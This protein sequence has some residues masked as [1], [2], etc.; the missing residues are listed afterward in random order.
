M[1]RRA[2]QAVRRPLLLFALVTGVAVAPAHAEPVVAISDDVASNYSDSRL[3]GLG[4]KHARLIT[5]WDS[6]SS[7]SGFVQGWLDAV[8]AAGMEPQIA[9]RHRRA[10]QCP[11]DPCLLPSRAQYR[12][13]IRAFVER[14]PRVRTYTTWNEANHVSQPTADSPEAAASFYEELADA[15][16]TCTIVAADVLDAGSYVSWLQRWQRA[17][18]RRPRLWGLHN[19]G[20]VT[21]GRTSGTDDVLAVVPGELWLEETGGIVVR[22]NSEGREVLRSDE[23]RAAESVR[24]AFEIARARPRIT[25]MAIY[26]WRAGARDHF[27]SGLVRPDGTARPSLDEVRTALGLGQMPSDPPSSSTGGGPGPAPASPAPTTAPALRASWSRGRLVVRVSCPACSGRAA[28]ALRIRARGRRPVLHRLGVRRFAP[29]ATWR[30][31]VSG[32][33]RGRARRATTLHVRVTAGGQSRL[34]VL[35]RP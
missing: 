25:R 20:D 4:L 1:G 17:T 33:L 11:G 6:A 12:A 14:F 34:V 35:R 23:R 28:V 31:T 26:Q 32:R 21:Y 22:R 18:A 29:S 24:R 5:S 13:A 2:T 7:Q 30:F 27:D 16:P 3:R 8:A 15:C 19:Y 10:D 9:F